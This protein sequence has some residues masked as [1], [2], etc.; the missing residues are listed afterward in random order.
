METE[1]ARIATVRKLARNLIKECGIDHP[2]VLLNDVIKKLRESYKI[3]VYKADFGDELSGMM[4]T[5]QGDFLDDRTDDIFYNQNHHVRRQRFTVAHEIGHLLMGTTHSN[6]AITFEDSNEYEKEADCFASEL[7]MPTDWLKKDL[8]EGGKVDEFAW[9]YFVSKDAM[10]WKISNN[11]LL[12]YV[13][14]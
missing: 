8:Q 2:P 6:S 14:L 11:S 5:S 9:K 7:L 10:G 3:G 13:K 4:V 1:K 12:K